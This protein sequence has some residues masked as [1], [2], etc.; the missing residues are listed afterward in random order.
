MIKVG[1]IGAGRIAVEGHIPA[2]LESSRSQLVG[3]WTRSSDKC[4]LLEQKY[5]CQCYDNYSTF[6]SSSPAE[7]IIICSPAYLHAP[8]ARLCADL[9]KHVLIEKPL[10]INLQEALSV[11]DTC[12]NAGVV[13]GVCYQRRVSPSLL[14]LKHLLNAKKLGQ[15]IFA[16]TETIWNRPQ[17]YYSNGKGSWSIDGGGVLINQGIHSIDLL[18]FLF[19]PSQKVCCETQRRF[20][21]LKAEDLAVG[22]IKFSQNIVASFI[23]TSA[24]GVNEN[25]K[26]TVVGSKATAV[27]SGNRLTLLSQ[28]LKEQNKIEFDSDITLQELI[29]KQFEIMLNSISKQNNPSCTGEEALMSLATVVAA[30]ESAKIND[31]VDVA[32]VNTPDSF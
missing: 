14:K 6:L 26:V 29:Q 22:I 32:E 13:L 24:A 27:L 19:G 11:V 23:C 15:V 17:N 7:L 31:W 1:V 2:I 28:E 8:I 3:I 9:G 16:K 21:N 5:G 25:H 30:Y 12:R 10:A 18:N 20:H 4:R